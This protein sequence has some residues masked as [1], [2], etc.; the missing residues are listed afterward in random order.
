M[1]HLATDL[2]SLLGKTVAE[3]RDVAE[4]GAR[5][6]VE[7][8][9]VGDA[10]LPAY[11]RAEE[12]DLRLRLRARARQLGDALDAKTSEQAVDRLVREVAYEHWHRMLFARFLA[13]SHLL[14][15]PGSRMPVSLVEVRELAR[16]RGEDPWALAGQ[17]AE[18]MLPAIFRSNDPALALELPPERL[19]RLEVLLEALPAE[20]F[21][22]DDALG[23]VYQFWQTK[24]KKQVNASG[25]KIG[26]EDLP[27][28]TQHFT[29]PYMVLFLL[30]NTL[31]AWSAGKVLAA[32]PKLATLATSEEELRRACALPGYSWAYLRFVR[33]PV[34]SGDWRPAAGTFPGWPRRAAEIAF[35]DPCCGSGHFLVEALSAFVA[36]RQ[37]EEGLS[38]RDAIAAVLRDN[39]HGLEIDPRCT[40]IAAFAVAFAAWRR[41]G[42]VE[43]LPPVQIA[44]S[45]LSVGVPKT[46]WLKIAGN[47]PELY[48]GM[49]R[50]HDLFQK[51]P[52]LGS[53]LDPR[54]D[55][56]QDLFSASLDRL[57]ER[58]IATS[59]K[60]EVQRDAA[61]A[62]VA[63]A[64][65]GMAL[66]VEK[67]LARYTLI[68]T[69]VPYLSNRKQGS[70]LKDFV[71][72]KY[73]RAKNDLGAAFTERLVGL[74]AAQGT[75][76]LV[77]PQSWFFKSSY[78]AMRRELLHERTLLVVGLLGVGAFR[79]I[80]GE[81][82]NVALS[83]LGEGQPALA[84][85]FAGTDASQSLGVDAKA[86][87]LLRGPW[88][89]ID[90]QAQLGNAGSRI[91]LSDRQAGD[92]LD[93]VVDAPQGI[94]TGD[95]D[96]WS[97]FF[98]ELPNFG[99]GWA[100]FQ[101][102]VSQTTPYG[103][104]T[105]AL[106]WREEGDGMVRPRKNCSALRRLG[107]AIS[108]SGD[109]QA[110]LYTGERFDSNVAPLVPRDETLLPALWAFCSSD[111][112]K[113]EVRKIDK[114]MKVTNVPLTQVPFDQR[115]WKRVARDRF[116]SGVPA[117]FTEDLTQW[118]FHGHPARSTSP[119]QVA[120]ARLVGY[121]WPSE[122]DSGMQLSGEA[123]E[124]VTRSEELLG[125]ADQDG[126][127]C[128]SSLRGEEPGA[129]RLRA[130]LAA[131]FGG[132]WGAAKEREL[133]TAACSRSAKL[134]EWLRDEFFEEHCALFHQRPFVWHVWDGRKDGFHALVNYHRLA[135]GGG[136]GRQLLESLAFTYLG[137]WIVRQRRAA[138]AGETGAEVRL[139]VALGVQGELRRILE[140]ETPYDLFVRWKPLHAQAIGWEPDID[141]GVRLNARPFVVATLEGG[142]KG[143]GLFRTKPNIH[144][145]KDRGAEPKCERG[146]FPWFYDAQG[147]FHGER[148]NDLHISLD[149]KCRAREARKS[150]ETKA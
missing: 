43:P 7:A 2:R 134:E 144:W 83:I 79:E 99:N 27:A 1:S 138:D 92:R 143:A 11:L 91:L 96:R 10:K 66:A 40:Q 33:D 9:G 100:P 147:N 15:D 133:L 142:R 70:G 6:T 84:H 64:A 52:T 22:A 42:R 67:L 114:S 57:E 73:R 108:Q 149:E 98:P 62:E 140:G 106:D 5:A 112:Y 101:T 131:A 75:L 111:E 78:E 141:D 118:V 69:N 39:L 124:W 89:M 81:V 104:R 24:R 107:V 119:L 74:L 129:A 146:D 55:V 60:Q 76:G 116:G 110:T 120:V 117:P 77:T 95:D 121:Q 58:L 68:A 48:R 88:L 136:K 128:L 41:L 28:V 32:Q 103:G 87:H 145:K 63:V 4:L 132:V 59:A 21:T 14:I 94:K 16:E 130:L 150:A 17:F 25:R 46:E 85:S 125:I 80:T 82:V 35:L 86:L 115:R 139:A 30:H 50:L 123:R 93:S 38:T 37:H 23:W 18:R 8:L 44:C 122:R 3:A 135:E 109:L 47:D 53:L 126:V 105:L 65:A 19:N 29:E 56:G 71:T 137:E 51:A 61:A 34:D 12:K 49:E 90:Q 102:T 148:H 31:G 54:K 127:V 45:G 20:V 113:K 13:D 72:E 97:R 26:A 36:L